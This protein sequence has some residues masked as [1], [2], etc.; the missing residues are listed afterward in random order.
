MNEHTYDYDRRHQ[1][2]PAVGCEE[3]F[4]F[5]KE[6]YLG[7]LCEAGEYRAVARLE[8]LGPSMVVVLSRVAVQLVARLAREGFSGF[9][10]GRTYHPKE[11]R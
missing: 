2:L 9:A 5:A 6:R 4:A 3:T 1:G 7:L 8:N 11:T 10:R